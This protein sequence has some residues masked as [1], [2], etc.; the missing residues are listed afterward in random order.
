MRL[1]SRDITNTR[2]I[3]SRKKI[4]GRYA[5]VS[6]C[7]LVWFSWMTERDSTPRERLA[8]LSRRE[9]GSDD[10][11]FDA[12]A[13]RFYR[14]PNAEDCSK[15][16]PKSALGDGTR[17]RRTRSSARAENVADPPPPKRKTKFGDPNNPAAIGGE[18]PPPPTPAP[19]QVPRDVLSSAPSTVATTPT[20]TPTPKT[21]TL[22][23]KMKKPAAPATPSITKKK[24]RNRV[25]SDQSRKLL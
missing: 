16:Y 22:A 13:R 12:I 6:R 10:E 7:A 9:D 23:R 5:N 3:V 2:I 15:F 19:A 11:R 21:P 25:N 20:P 8:E 17:G 14:Y 1:N 24:K 18:M 4:L